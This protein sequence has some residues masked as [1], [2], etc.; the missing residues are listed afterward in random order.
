VSRK[1]FEVSTDLVANVA[2]RGGAVGTDDHGIHL[3]VLHQVAARVINDDR[4]GY[5]L[6]P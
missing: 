2:A 1:R 6:S 4:V 3:A 5:T